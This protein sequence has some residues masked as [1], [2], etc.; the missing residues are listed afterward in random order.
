MIGTKFN[1]HGPLMI[2]FS[3]KLFL[4]T[5]I[6]SRVSLTWVNLRTGA[7]DAAITDSRRGMN[8]LKNACLLNK[9]PKNVRDESY[10]D[11]P[12]TWLRF[13][14]E[15]QLYQARKLRHKLLQV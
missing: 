15:P 6:A 9:M 7:L 2:S 14:K 5:L 13:D 10:L 8:S 12:E 3:M 1:V 11:K 4:N